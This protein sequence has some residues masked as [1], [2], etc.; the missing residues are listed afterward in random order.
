MLG[1]IVTNSAK[2]KEDG[3]RKKFNR[4]QKIETIGP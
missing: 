2:D 4:D 3:C 1:D